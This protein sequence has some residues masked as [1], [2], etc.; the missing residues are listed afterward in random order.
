V[1]KV[2]NSAV[3]QAQIEQ[4]KELRASRD[5]AETKATL[6]ALTKQRQIAARQ[7]AGTGRQCGARQSHGRRDLKRFGNRL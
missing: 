3:R 1:L 6:D 4:L 7:F 2:D 5:E